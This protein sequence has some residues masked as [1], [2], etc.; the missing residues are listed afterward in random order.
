MIRNLYHLVLVV[1]VWL[2]KRLK[3]FE[4]LSG[5][6]GSTRRPNQIAKKYL[7]NL[8]WKEIKLQ[9]VSKQAYHNNAFND[10][11]FSPLI[12]LLTERYILLML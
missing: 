12:H 7:P 2:L 11:S 9:A 3:I 5:F 6:Q 10:R 1:G 8:I 4:N